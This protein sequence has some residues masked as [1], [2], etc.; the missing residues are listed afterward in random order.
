MEQNNRKHLHLSDKNTLTVSAKKHSFVTLLIAFCF[1][2]LLYLQTASFKYTHFDDDVIIINNIPFFSKIA[3]A[4]QAFVT[5]AFIR[6]GGAFYRPL[7]TLSFMADVQLSGGN[8]PWMLHL[9]N[10]LLM[11]AIACCLF[12]FLKCFSIP[13]KFALLCTLVYCAHPLFVSNVAFIPTRGELLL[14]LFTLLSFIFLNDFT[15]QKKSASLVLHWAAF[16]LALFCK[17]TAALLPL[18]FITYFF[19]FST[20]KRIEKNHVLLIMLYAVSGI[21]WYWLRS[22][23]ITNNPNLGEVRGFAAVL[24]G[25][26]TI[27]ESLAKFFFPFDLAPIP[28]FSALKTSAG[29]V[30]MTLIIFI[31]FKNKECTKNEKIF[32]FAWFLVLMFPPMLFKGEI[33][34]FDHRFFLPLI[35]IMLFVIFILPKK[36]LETGSSKQLWIMAA[37]VVFLSS[38]TF[39]KSRSFSDPMTFYDSAI[40]YYTNSAPLYNNRGYLKYTRHDVQGAFDDY[41]KALAV[42]PAYFKTYFNIGLAKGDAGDFK[43]AIDNYT[44]VIGISPS[45]YRAYYNRAIACISLRNY[46]DALPDLNTYIS[47]YPGNPEAYN[48]RGITMGSTGNYREAMNNFTKAIECKPDYVEAYFNRALSRFTLNDF[49]GAIDDCNKV[50]SLKPDEKRAANLKTKSMNELQMKDGNK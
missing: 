40:S 7:Q 49:T 18:L 19:I 1:P 10:I 23:A 50:L 39:I 44:K 11:G 16:T 3:N 34:Y 47:A 24:S 13:P 43:G 12:L 17:E 8:H 31:F 9:S 35:G 42:N 6:R 32:C 20:E 5:D 2:V 14:V 41:N 26:Q 38:F 33:D 25:I 4:P 46:E 45:Y 15:Q 28:H 48:Y 29:L 37:L 27:P 36:W 30:I 22:K 21:I